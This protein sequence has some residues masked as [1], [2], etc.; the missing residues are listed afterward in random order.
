MQALTKS[1]VHN[2][3]LYYRFSNIYQVLRFMAWLSVVAPSEWLCDFNCC[4]V[5]KLRT[6]VVAWPP[7]ECTSV[8][9]TVGACAARDG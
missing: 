1:V 6:R 4:F 3:L 9:G 2:R 8:H 5:V 7:L